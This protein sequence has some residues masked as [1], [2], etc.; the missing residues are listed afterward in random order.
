MELSEAFDTLDHQI[1]LNKLKYYGV[2]DTSLKWFSSYLTGRQQYVEIDGYSAGLLPLTTGVPQVS[3]LG[4]L[5]FFI[6]MNGI[7]HA[8]DYFDFISYA[9]FKVRYKRQ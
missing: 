4:P 1:L 3:I 7:P 5:L 8:T 9:V 6:F 2:N